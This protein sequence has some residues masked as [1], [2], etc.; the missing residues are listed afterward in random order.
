MALISGGQLKENTWW[1][2]ANVSNHIIQII[3]KKRSKVDFRNRRKNKEGGCIDVVYAW[4][5]LHIQN[6]CLFSGDYRPLGDI[7][8]KKY[9]F[10]QL[11]VL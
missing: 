2:V 9:V 7:S 6:K 3:K 4:L 8:K 5:E 11:N 10:K 1:T